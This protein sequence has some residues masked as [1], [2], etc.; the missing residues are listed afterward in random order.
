MEIHSTKVTLLANERFIITDIRL[1]LD[2]KN[3]ELHKF[4][5]PVNGKIIKYKGTH[6]MEIKKATV[7]IDQVEENASRDDQNQNVLI[8]II[9]AKYI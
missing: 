3:M 2:A 1:T 5:I 7:K 6:K 4:K 8:L 9:K